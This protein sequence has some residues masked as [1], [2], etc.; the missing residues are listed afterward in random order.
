MDARTYLAILEH[1]DRQIEHK[2]A[3][4]Q[5]WR[6]MAESCTASTEGERVQ[7]TPNKQRMESAVVAYVDL[8]EELQ[9]EISEATNKRQ[10]I[11][12]T[13]EQLPVD[14]YDVIYRRYVKRQQLK[15]IQIDLG[16]SHTWISNAHRRGMCDLQKILD[17][18]RNDTQ[19][20]IR[21]KGG[22]KN[23]GVHESLS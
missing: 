6:E 2:L 19:D 20:E 15:Q 5:H 12:H 1:L 11:I 8:C 18:T 10:E 14:E 3:E 21:A 7:S 22:N 17:K 9:A 13:I 23:G 16:K 4:I